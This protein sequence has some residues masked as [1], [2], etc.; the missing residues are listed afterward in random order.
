M[1]AGRNSRRPDRPRA[2]AAGI[3]SELRERVIG[4]E[5]FDADP[6]GFIVRHRQNDAVVSFDKG[7]DLRMQEPI[8]VPATLGVVG[9]Q[10]P[11]G[12]ETR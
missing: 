1:V 10:H 6:V 4:F 5:D 12:A 9:D 2:I 11:E 7:R 3:Q 8:A